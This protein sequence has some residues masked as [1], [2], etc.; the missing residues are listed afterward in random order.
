MKTKIEAAANVIVILVAVVVGSVFLKDRLS[1]PAPEPDAVKPG[2]KLANLGGWDWAAHYQTQVLGLRKRCRAILS[3]A[4]SPAASR[5]KLHDC[6]GLSRHRRY[7]EGGCAI[8]RATGSRA[9]GSAFGKIEDLW[10]ANSTVSGQERDSLERMDWYALAQIVT[11][12]KAS[13]DVAC[14]PKFSVG[15]GR[16]TNIGGGRSNCAV[17]E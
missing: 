11:G 13:L 16:Q 7:G 1:T 14:N 8:G 6:G 4:H 2:D 10:N 12:N 15:R 17:P 3:A 9:C 5:V